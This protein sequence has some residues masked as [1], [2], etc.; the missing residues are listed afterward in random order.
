M[1]ELARGYRQ[2]SVNLR[3]LTSAYLPWKQWWTLKSICH[4]DFLLIRGD[5][6]VYQIGP[7]QIN[8]YWQQQQWQ[9]PHIEQLGCSKLL[10]FMFIIHNYMYMYMWVYNL[11]E[12]CYLPPDVRLLFVCFVDDWTC[13]LLRFIYYSIYWSVRL[14]SACICQFTPWQTFCIV[15][16]RMLV[17]VC[18]C[19]FARARACVCVCAHLCA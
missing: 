19:V 17:C 10:Y 14:F 1:K 7:H 15:C 3:T 4:L 12:P 5:S 18:V 13:D 9:L 6:I 16:P 11:R 2:S 8:P